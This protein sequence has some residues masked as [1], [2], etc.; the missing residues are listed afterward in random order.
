ME[1]I[2]ILVR[3]KKKARSLLSLLKSL[4]FVDSVNS[5]SIERKAST[6]AITADEAEDAFGMWRDTDITAE[7]LRESAWKRP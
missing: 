5:R 1:Q 3:D 7:S 4:D 6:E 2:T